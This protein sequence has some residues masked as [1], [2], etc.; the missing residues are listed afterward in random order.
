MS[1]AWVAVIGSLGGVVVAGLLNVLIEGRRDRAE[2]RRWSRERAARL[3]DRR[4]EL[5]AALPALLEEVRSRAW[6][7]VDYRKSEPN[8]R[9]DSYVQAQSDRLEEANSVLGRTYY[10]SLILGMSEKPADAAAELM[11]WRWEIIEQG[12]RDVIEPD[13]PNLSLDED[14][15]VKEVVAF[16]DAAAEALAAPLVPDQGARHFAS[17]SKRGVGFRRSPVGP[18]TERAGERRR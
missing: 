15:W 11:A 13:E 8:W 18:L 9:H 10:E 17:G 3:E 6:S 1:T 16:V 14:L 7:Y 12:Y 5:A 2:E 4:R